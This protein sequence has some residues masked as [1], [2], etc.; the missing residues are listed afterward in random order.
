MKRTMAIAAIVP[1]AML[2][3]PAPVAQGEPAQAQ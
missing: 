3:T 2:F 1:I